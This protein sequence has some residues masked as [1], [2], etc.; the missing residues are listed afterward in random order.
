MLVEGGGCRDGG[1]EGWETAEYIKQVLRTIILWSGER[2]NGIIKS[3]WFHP[4]F[5]ACKAMQLL[6]TFMIGRI[7]LGTSLCVCVC[8]VCALI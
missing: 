8:V 5:W 3:K 2:E 7:G 4:I 1:T 6:F